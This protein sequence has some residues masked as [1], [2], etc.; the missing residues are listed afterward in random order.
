MGSR[1][2]RIVDWKRA[3]RN[4]GYCIET[5]AR[6][7]DVTLRQLERYFK[8]CHGTCPKLWCNALRMK[9]AERLLHR[10]FLVKQVAQRLGYKHPHHFARAFK[11]WKGIS[12]SEARNPN[13]GLV[14]YQCQNR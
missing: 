1:L 2:D 13:G 14:P 10:G 5:L 12:P 7:M 9:E 11:N 6:R 8:S 3:A 4:S